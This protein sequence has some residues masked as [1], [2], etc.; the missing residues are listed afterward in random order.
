MTPS[1]SPLPPPGGYVIPARYWAW[2]GTPRALVV[3]VWLAALGTGGAFTYRALHIFDSPESMGPDRRRA[4]GNGGHAQIDFGGQYVMG[5]MIVT[6]HGRQLYHRQA[7]WKV[8]R[9]SFLV[10][11]ETP[12]QQYEAGLPPIWRKTARAEEDW[13]HDS[14]NMMMWFMGSE[15]EP[16]KEWK[17]V[18]GATALLFAQSPIGNPLI[19]V[20]YEKAA[21]DTVTPAVVAKVNEPVIGG[22]LYPPVHGLFYAPLALIDRPQRAYQ[23]FQIFCALLVPLTGLG[24]KVLTRGRVWWS[25]ATL[26]I[27]IHPGMRAGLDLG[28]NPC[29]SL[30]IVVWGWALASRGYNVAGGAVWGLLAFKP[31]WAAALFLVPLLTRRWRFTLAMLG[32]GAALGAITLP[33]VGLDSWFHWLKIGGEASEVY[34]T[35]ENWVCLSRDLQGI[36]RRI[37]LDFTKPDADRNKPIHDKLAW[38]LWAAV[39]GATVGVYL[40]RADRKRATG[41]GAGFLFLGAYLTCYHFM[42]YDA[43]ISF[44]AVAVLF[45]DPKRFFRTR[46]FALE[47]APVEPHAPANRDL[48]APRVVPKPLGARMRGYVNSFPIT[49]VIALFVAENWVAGLEVEATIGMKYFVA[50]GPENTTNPRVP[51]IRAD[52]GVKY[53]T[54]TYLLLALW[55]WCGFRLVRGDEREPPLTP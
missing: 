42:F 12:I 26:C 14:N 18:G 37:L 23:L 2:L 20:A 22:P 32:T 48:H 9:E 29:V 6:G 8:V 24:V 40:L 34:K 33:F 17:K 21:A 54:D 35:N 46:T 11:D 5:R 38:G 7:Q 19:A 3:L 52:T 15:H 53:P 47:P 31:V 43:L 41:V 28:Q 45:A 36:P 44:I 55:A 51:S 49:V 39:M 50:P 27:F 30:C 25:V 16:A 4:D 1:P 13:Q 10:G